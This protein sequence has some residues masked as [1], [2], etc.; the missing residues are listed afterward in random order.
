MTGLL[1]LVRVSLIVAINL[2]LPN[3][4][5]YHSKP[6]LTISVTALG[7]IEQV[8]PSRAGAQVGDYVCVSGQIGDA[9]LD[10]NT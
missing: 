6:Q 8:K 4:W 10:Y 7:W 2:V 5:R 3:W 9:A 1:D